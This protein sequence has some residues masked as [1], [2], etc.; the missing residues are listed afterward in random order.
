M[1][2][3]SLMKVSETNNSSK[4]PDRSVERVSLPSAFSEMLLSLA[5]LGETQNLSTAVE[6]LGVS[7][8][9]IRRHIRKLEQL[10]GRTFF[11]SRLRN[12][13]ATEYGKVAVIEARQIIDRS[14]EWISGGLNSPLGL[15]NIEV[16]VDDDNWIYAQQQPFSKFWSM[17]PPILQHGFAA[18]VEAKGKLGHPAIDRV[19]PYILVHR[20]YREEWL[21]VEVGEKSAYGTFKGISLARSDVSRRMDLGEEYRPLIKYWHKCFETVS[22]N[23]GHWYEHLSAKMPRQAGARSV[24]FNYQRLVLFCTFADGAP[25]IAVFS[26]RTDNTEVPRLPSSR[27]ANTKQELLMDLEI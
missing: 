26:A 17:A 11:A 16:E 5:V 14:I 18:W 27:K 12:Y 9:T 21:T 2:A 10:T 20:K 25:A 24:N 7:R 23:G 15:S 13:E 1:V 4:G 3:F 6:R 19:S 22:G 8:Q